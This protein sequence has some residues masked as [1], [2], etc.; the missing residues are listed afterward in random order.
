MADSIDEK[1]EA[2]FQVFDSI[3]E[4]AAKDVFEF[5]ENRAPKSSILAPKTVYMN[6]LS[7]VLVMMDGKPFGELSAD[8]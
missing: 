8:E 6:I 3:M 7:R 2:A 5:L 4:H 1:V